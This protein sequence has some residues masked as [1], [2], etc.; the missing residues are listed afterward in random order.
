M[1]EITTQTGFKCSISKRIVEDWRLLEAISDIESKEPK[2][3]QS[4]TFAMVN[5]V[6]GENKKDLIEHIQKLNDGLCPTS[7]MMK[8]TND[9]IT[10]LKELKN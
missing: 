8:E 10:Q 4:G 5:I 2:R 9:V 1:V 3:M 7:E 6:F